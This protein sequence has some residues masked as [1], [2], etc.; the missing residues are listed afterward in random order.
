MN[1]FHSLL[2]LLG[3][4]LTWDWWWWGSSRAADEIWPLKQESNTST[5]EKEQEQKPG[6]AKLNWGFAAF[7]ALMLAGIYLYLRCLWK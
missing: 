6:R 4:V 5:S 3:S 1:I 7:L 2:E